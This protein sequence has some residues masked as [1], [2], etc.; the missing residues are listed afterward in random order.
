[1]GKRS[2][3]ERKARDFY[4]TPDHAIEPL[5]PHLP[6]STE[7]IEPCAGDYRL[8][9]FL[10]RHG[11]ICV[12]AYDIYPQSPKVR[13]ADALVEPV[14][15]LVIT[16]PPWDRKILHPMI[17]HFG[18]CWLLFDADWAHTK[19]SSDMMKRCRTIV[20]VGRVKWFDNM[21]GKDNAA[22]Y[23]FIPEET[24]TRFIGR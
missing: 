7:F 10:V 21:T 16:N 11:H 8:A 6:E 14:S 1:M 13:Q 2:N 19:Q 9:D 4:A 15:G 5:L 12:D 20:S 3:F 24:T 22:W 18:H 23:E 17:D